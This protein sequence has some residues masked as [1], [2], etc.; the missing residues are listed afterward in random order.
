M[1]GA[2]T[3]ESDAVQQ[4]NRLVAEQAAL[5][6]VATLVAEGVPVD[7]LFGAV[8]EEVGR[9]FCADLAAMG[10]YLAADSMLAVAG[11]VPEGESPAISRTWALEGDSLSAAV[12]RTGRPA[13]RDHWEAAAGPIAALA[14]E[15]DL[16][17]SAASPI[18]V[19]G[20]TWGVLLINSKT[21]PFPSGTEWR[22]AEFA[23]LIA[24]AIANVE[25]RAA[26]GRLA[27]EQ[28]A[29]RRV[30]TLVAHEKPAA[31]VFAAV[32]EEVG[33]LLGVS[34]ATVYHYEDDG[35]AT[36]T[37]DWGDADALL[38]AGAQFRLDG[39]SLV[40][41]VRRSAAP[42]RIDDFAEATSVI[43]TYARKRGFRSGVGT[44]I[45]V[46][47]RLWGGIVAVSRRPEPL[48]A[49]AEARI[50]HFTDLV[51]TSIANMEARAELA[52]SRARIVAAADE[53]RR[54]V[55]RDLHDG[56]QQRL[57]HTVI[58][59]KMALQAVEANDRA[60]ALLREA[61]DQAQ[62]ATAELR[63][64][65]HGILPSV[66]MYG[67]LAAG[68]DAL[69][70]RLELPVAVDVS[71]ARLP[72]PVEA[73]AYFVV[74]EALTNVA[75]HSRARQATVTARVAG[76]TLRVDVHD[77]GVGGARPDGRGLL[78]LADRLAAIGGR[79]EVANAEGG[80][81]HVAASIPLAASG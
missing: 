80:G 50:A 15:L 11:W 9:L 58:T 81:T 41:R 49:D 52:A 14:R 54:R 31:E 66:L 62:R 22:L 3:S 75:K 12:V 67:G 34:V 2:S 20:R 76:D 79:L 6:R 46:E 10:Q 30:A 26:A 35:T 1:D 21:S 51:A 13:R 65:A 72:A 23:E 43:G 8:T 56:A 5:R 37:A 16:R 63:E 19:D 32:A 53:E 74:A 55:V 25:A 4:R 59:V 38:P 17:S 44:P 7:R 48:P 24:T 77:D 39:D 68:V 40:T 36:V 42:A 73:T 29:L 33:R 64:L 27:D 70:A 78:G 71:P 69:V 28:V 47:G 45:V 18:V 57:V 61:S 60:R